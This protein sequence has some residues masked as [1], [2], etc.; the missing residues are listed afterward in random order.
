M[1]QPFRSRPR[2][3][4]RQ[5]PTEPEDD[6]Q[7][8]E[9]VIE[10]PRNKLVPVPIPDLP[11]QGESPRQGRRS[12]PPSGS[13]QLPVM[14]VAEPGLLLIAIGMMVAG[15]FFT[16]LNVAGNP[17]PVLE[18]WPSVSLFVSLVWS[19]V[20]L[21][22]RNATA[23]LGGAGAAGLSISLLLHTQDVAKFQETVV[24]VI[25]ISIGLAIIVRGLL[26]RPRITT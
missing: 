1:K 12:Q 17:D 14:R 26:L 3:R 11:P 20:A 13:R 4:P 16:Y 18:W 19:M 8:V 15:I 2:V 7:I 25:L 22:R 23:F 10:E 5:E 6:D 21:T 9:G 24:G